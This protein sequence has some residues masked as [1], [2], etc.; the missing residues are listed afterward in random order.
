MLCPVTM[1][2]ENVRAKFR[3]ITYSD[4]LYWFSGNDEGFIPDTEDASEPGV[5]RWASVSQDFREVY[6]YFTYRLDMQSHRLQEIACIRFGNKGRFTFNRDVV[7]HINY[8]LDKWNIQSVEFHMIGGNPVLPAYRKF[9]NA[10]HG[11]EF[12]LHNVSVDKYGKFHDEH[13]FE[14]LVKKED[15]VNVSVGETAHWDR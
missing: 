14:I 2:A 15:K 9:V 11:Q 3:A 1:V 6:G 10:H 5:Y 7:S 12:V 8:I 4:R 13:V